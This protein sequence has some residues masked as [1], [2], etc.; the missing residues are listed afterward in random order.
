[1]LSPKEIPTTQKAWGLRAEVP[2]AWGLKGWG[3]KAEAPKESNAEGKGTADKAAADRAGAV[4]AP[5]VVTGAGDKPTCLAA[6]VPQ[7]AECSLTR[8]PP[9][10]SHPLPPLGDSPACSA[11]LA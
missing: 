11:F 9:G 10:I 3:L 1:M 8:H 4:E 7:Q 5:V 6:V 2:V